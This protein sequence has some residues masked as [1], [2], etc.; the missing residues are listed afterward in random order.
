MSN[1][2]D[3]VYLIDG[4]AYIY[5]AYHALTPLSN[6]SGLPTH[7]VYGFTN[8]LLRVL[9][10]KEPKFLAVAFDV[11][12]PTFRHALY[13]DYKANR[14]PMP[15]DLVCQIP[16]I[17]EIVAAH[18]ILSL[19]AAGNEADDLLASAVARL[20][21]EGVPVVLV[22]G[23]KDLLQL[24]AENVTL[25]DPMRDVLMD[26][27]AVEKKYNLP[28]ERLL[29]FFA[30]VGDSSDNVPGVAGIGPKTAEKLINQ[31][32][33]LEG[34][35]SNLEGLSQAKLREKLRE[36]RENAFLSRRLIALKKDLPTPAPEEYALPPP[37][38]DR[39]RQLYTFLEFSRLL[40]T[41]TS[42][43]ALENA[44]FE[45][46]TSPAQLTEVCARLHKAPFLVL[47]TETTSLDPLVAEL[48]GISL[49]AEPATACYLPLGHRRED[50][51]ALPGQLSLAEVRQALSPLLEDEGL[52]KLG[53][54]LKFDLAILENQGFRLR[55]PLWDTMIASYLLDPSRRSQKLDDLSEDIL[56]RRLT[57]FQ[58]V[59]DK[60]RRPDSFAYVAPDR[61]KDY[62][63][64][65]VA[66]TCLLWQHF[67]PL[68]TSCDL[69][70]LFADLEM[71]LVPIL[72]RMERAGIA[73]DCAR[74]T[75][76]AEEFGTQ[77]AELERTIH[78]LAGEEFN[79]NSP[80]QLGEILFAKLHLPQGRKTKTGFS[81]DFKV[82]EKLA[83]QHD[84]PAAIITH[85]NLSKLKSTYVD[86]LAGLVHPRTGRIH[87]SFNQTVTATGRLSSSNPNLQNIPV[88]TPEGQ[89]IRAA[90]VAAPGH[91]F[92]AADY[93]QIDLRVLAHYSQDQALLAAFR[94]GRD[95]HSQTAAEIFGLNPAFITPQMRR[96]AKSIN[97]GIVYGMS[98]FGL[99]EQLNLSR[100]EAA[101][102]IERYFT[103]YPGVKRFMEEIVALARREGFVTTLLKRRRLLPDINS[104]NKAS[105]EF[106]ERTAINTPIQGTA[107]DI[108]KLATIACHRQLRQAGLGAELLLQ[109]H[110]E[111]VFEVP[112]AEVAASQ[113][114]VQK[115]M[116]SVLA[117]DVPLVVNLAA[118]D[119]LAQL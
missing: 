93:S 60:D 41:K 45:L 10:E 8:I 23:D 52:P 97:F 32:G 26:P 43:P 84:L 92:L 118:G 90:F 40:K 72:V 108:I 47:D 46:V 54:N 79:I 100:K 59:T 17:K 85:R 27:A 70:P 65:D 88:R 38:N 89:K 63:C 35:Y 73:V 98:A 18:N 48:V 57:S 55:G 113:A 91:R 4:S 95:I 37:D 21:A 66:A 36:Q 51:S 74:L 9:R 86:K 103:H 53:H 87:S 31:F 33:S 19:E 2:P 34:L 12:G 94:A 61:A 30:L 15:D 7:A 14:P 78:T 102:F 16:H 76:L 75:A 11:R 71:A 42:S 6:A 116:E 83:A 115:A 22:S 110:D 1:Q 107:A 106:A 25:W 67:Q 119:N 50:G 104:P 3:P 82:L 117:L 80:R 114:I 56:G 20:S 99:A 69:W 5:R 68:L 29:D 13:R 58:E 44:G 64:E 112:I 109:V 96:V 28:P 105:R 101:T 77:L 24:V 39:L 81:T 111:L 62:S 49:C